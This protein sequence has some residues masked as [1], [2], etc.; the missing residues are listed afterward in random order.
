VDFAGTLLLTGAVF[1]LGVFAI[2][3]RRNIVA[4]LMGVELMINASALNMV[5]FSR[6]HGDPTSGQ[7]VALFVI[8]LAACE[9]AIAFGLFINFYRNM[10]SVEI[11]SAGRLTQ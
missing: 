3:S 4:I 11:G 8:V 6:F 2:L 5:A 9:A 1:C 10:K 7:V